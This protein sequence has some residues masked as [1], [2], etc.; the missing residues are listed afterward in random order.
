MT[1]PILPKNLTEAQAEQAGSLVKGERLVSLSE[2]S[3]GF[4]EYF[5]KDLSLEPGKEFDNWSKPKQHQAKITALCMENVRQMA[6]EMNLMKRNS[7]GIWE[8]TG[9]GTVAGYVDHLF[10]L[11]RAALTNNPVMDLVSVVPMTRAIGRLF[12]LNYLIGQTKGNITKGDRVF[13]ALTGFNGQQTYTG[14]QVAQEGQAATGTGS[15]AYT[16]TLSYVPVLPGTVTVSIDTAGANLIAR[17]NGNGGFTKIAGTNT[18]SAS[19]INY[20]TGAISITPG[21]AFGSALAVSVDYTYDS[22]ISGSLPQIDVGIVASTLIAGDRSCRVRYSTNGAFD[23]KQEFGEDI[24]AALVNGVGGLIKAEIAREV[25]SDLWRAASVA[26]STFSVGTIGNVSKV[27][28][29]ADLLV[30]LNIADGSIYSATQRAHGNWIVCDV[31]A[32]NI[33]RSIPRPVFE[34]APIDQSTQGTQYIGRLNGQYDVWMDKFLVN[35]SGSSAYGNILMGHKGADFWDAGY[36]YAPY[37][38]LYTTAS[39]TLD[40]MFTRK[41]IRTRYAK[42]LISPAY[43]RKITLA[44]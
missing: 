20:A 39:V 43:F 4:A 26:S 32:A 27:E 22:E 12:F 16:T 13:D 24:E 36:V 5:T 7:Q 33:V 37:Q 10:P 8:T 28:H 31:N 17:D 18:I 14:Q 6:A 25:I 29:Y 30:E 15:T 40:D 38:P 9:S 21:T 42:K 23:F 3:G 35:E 19:S 1:E 44:A 11:I 41:G 2:S 34:A